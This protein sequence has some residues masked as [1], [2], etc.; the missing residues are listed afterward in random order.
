MVL[1]LAK[2]LMLGLSWQKGLV[3]VS[4][5]ALEQAIELNGVVPD[6]NR[7]AFGFGRVMADN[8]Q[9]IEAH[10]APAPAPDDSVE[11]LIAR[12]M[13]FLTGYQNK[14]YA[15]RYKG[16]LDALAA[17]LP[18]GS[19]DLMR[20]AA[21]SLFKLMAYKD[22]YEVARLL[23]TSRDKARAEFDGDFNMTF[24]MAPPLISKMGPT[25]R[26]QTRE[27]AQRTEGPPLVMAKFCGLCGTHPSLKHL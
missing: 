20:A 11:G 10:L 24:H 6:K 1:V 2:V 21:K 18:E 27:F 8:P 13:E 14:A 3:P 4:L 15:Q 23:I 5:T 7:A 17:K 12:R 19:E 9:A 22:E 26:H 16:K 25:G